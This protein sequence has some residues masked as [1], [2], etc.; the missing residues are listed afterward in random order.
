[1]TRKVVLEIAHEQGID[2]KEE[3]F[4][5]Q[6]LDRADEAFLTNT[7]IEI[8][9]VTRVDSLPV[10]NGM[11]GSLTQSLHGHFLNLIDEESK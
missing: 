10:G 4:S 11:P 6:E 7:G 2:F 5:K 3:D 9:P 1:M 8:L